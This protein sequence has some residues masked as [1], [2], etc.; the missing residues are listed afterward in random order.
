MIRQIMRG[1]RIKGG[2]EQTMDNP[3][4]A[5]SDA[6]TE[7]RGEKTYQNAFL[8]GADPFVMTWQGKYYLYATNDPKGYRVYVSDDFTAWEEKGYCLRAEDVQGK[9][10]FW[11][12][13]VMERGGRFYMVY[14]SE[15]HIGIAQS[16]SPLG[17]F[18]QRE[19]KWLSEEKAIDG[20]FFADDDGEVYLY[21]VRLRGQ[22]EIYVARLNNEITEIDETHEKFLCR[23][24]EEWE[25]R[26]CKVTEG[27]FVL[28]HKGKYYLT[29]SANHTRSEDYAI[30][31]AVSDSPLGPFVKYKGN[32][33]LHKNEYASGVGH[34]SF[35]RSKD[36]KELICVYHRHFSKDTFR[37]RMICAD[38]AEFVAQA[39]GDDILV[40]HGPTGTP[41]KAF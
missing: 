28:K 32:P 29:Y 7:V 2:R 15:E 34:H 13:E 31:Y 40:V 19:K 5:Q 3:I 23:A 41:Q 16:D 4:K 37:P 35:T 1:Q 33:I 17:P 22:N 8:E 6:Q 39:D 18:V 26:D 21:Y 27:P 30:G 36:G 25:L 12:P 20:H 9:E 24:E 10:M 11:A 14:T 38:R